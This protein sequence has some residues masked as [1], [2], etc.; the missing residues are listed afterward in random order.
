MHYQPKGEPV[1][2]TRI[3]T[4]VCFAVVLLCIFTFFDTIWF[5]LIIAGAVLLS[6]TEILKA[7]APKKQ[8]FIFAG[9]IPLTLYT[10]LME[11]LPSAGSYLWPILTATVF[12]YA[13]LTVFSF[14]DLHF[15]KLGGCLSFGAIVLLGFYS[16]VCLKA[17]F[18]Q[19][20]YGYDALFYLFLSLGIA[21]G[22][23]VFAYFVGSFFGKHKMAPRLSPHKSVEGAF[24]GVAGSILISLLMLFAYGC[25]L[26]AL[27][28]GSYEIT[29]GS[30]LLTAVFA[31]GVSLVGMIGDLFASAVKRQSGI[32]DYGKIFPGHGGMLDRFDSALLT[33]PVVTA[34]VSI[35]P[36]ILR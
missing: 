17:M 21:W 4:A 25:I 34:A 33:M 16:A 27:D 29:G 11:Y 10:T 13:A 36:L 20:T 32:K 15:E 7:I 1:L 2:K 18:P 14:P 22:G 6:F 31:A 30:Y 19:D 12:Y 3:I 8:G 5:N 35:A 26:S 9:F 23:D 28:G 24:G